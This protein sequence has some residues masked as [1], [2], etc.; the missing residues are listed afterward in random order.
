MKRHRSLHSLSREHHPALVQAH[1]LRHLGTEVVTLSAEEVIEKFLSFWQEAL[2]DHFRKEEEILL[3]TLARFSKNNTAEITQLL[4]EHLDL[5][6][7]LDELKLSTEKGQI[8]KVETLNE[9]GEKLYSHIR[10]EEDLFF[11]IV[12]QKVPE[13]ELM[14]L[15]KKLES[16]C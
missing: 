16:P 2:I 8:P 4:F 12:E 10:F 9:F 13:E 3:P 11:P 6:S 14:L 1:N 15:L 5:R 7:R